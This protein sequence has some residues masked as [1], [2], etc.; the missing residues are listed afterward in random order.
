[1]K[2]LLTILFLFVSL[3][4]S[5][6]RYYV[7]SSNGNDGDPGTLALPWLTIAKVNGFTFAAGDTV[8]FKCGDTWREM[9]TIPRSGT[10]GNNMVFNVYSTGARPLI[11]GSDISAGWTDEGG[12]IWKS[13][14]TFA[15]DVWGVSPWKSDI[16]FYETGGTVTW[17]SHKVS[18]VACVDEYDWTQS[19][20]YIYVYAATDPD[21]RYTKIEIPQRLYSIWLPQRQYITIDS[22][23]L[24][25]PKKINVYDN[26][27]NTTGLTDFTLKN[28]HI[29]W[30]GTMHSGDGGTEDTHGYNVSVARSNMLIQ[31]NE[32]HNGGRRQISINWYSVNNNTADNIVIEN[33]WCHDG[34]HGSGMACD[35]TDNSNN[36]VTNIYVRNNLFTQLEDWGTHEDD[37]YSTFGSFRALSSGSSI[38]GIYIYNNVYKYVSNYCY[39]FVCVDNVY[40]Y[41]NTFYDLNHHFNTYAYHLQLAGQNG[42]SCTNVNIKNNIFYTTNTYSV[43]HS[44]MNINYY[45]AMLPAQV[46]MDYN[47]F[48]ELDHA[49]WLI[50]LADAIPSGGRYNT[51]NWATLKSTYGWQAHEPTLNTIPGWVSA[52]D[53]LNLAAGSVCIGTGVYLGG[54]YST[55]ILGNARANPPSI[56]AYEYD[57]DPPIL[58]T[59]IDISAAGSATTITIEDGTLQLYTNV[60]P[61]NAT[62]TTKTWS[63]IN[64]TGEGTITQT[65]VITAVS[66]GTVT[67]KALSNDA[68][69]IYDTYLI[70]ISNQDPAPGEGLPT[71]ITGGVSSGWTAIWA[72][73]N[74]EVT[75]DGGG[76][77]SDRGI[78]WGTS[79]N[80]TTAG[81]HGHSGTGEGSFTYTITGLKG[82][83]HYHFRAFATNGEGTAYSSDVEFFTP[84]FSTVTTGAGLNKRL[85]YGGKFV[86]ISR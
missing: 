20:G 70:T 15:V 82:L 42:Q 50:T 12:N 35:V 85:R 72:I 54:I 18:T 40:I 25:H 71:V 86:M 46:N 58:V 52:P 36:H 14:T 2:K 63:L 9:L 76:T 59:S 62:D 84:R 17:G 78:C 19:G 23:D 1:M 81:L 67:A 4:L 34:N 55:D 79:A 8:S 75:D 64:G 24:R 6:H 47:L 26:E 61:D 28:C 11:L 3:T 53:N 83:I 22:L 51:A 57:A 44:H 60:E 73:A 43:Q 65:G 5:A 39:Q 31:N 37:E 16:F 33:N 13:T 77:V 48:Y 10:A 7:S 66:D 68:S 45:N 27:P 29:A 38:S 41:N 69:G 21:A 49:L 56:G 80:P 32:I 30:V 74:G